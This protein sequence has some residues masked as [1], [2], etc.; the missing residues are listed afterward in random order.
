MSYNDYNYRNNRRRP[1]QQSRPRHISRRTRN[2]AIIIVAGLVIF[3]LFI[4]LIS[5]IANCI[6]SPGVDPSQ[7]DTATKGTEKKTKTTAK[8]DNISF[9]EP[10]MEYDEDSAAGEMSGDL[11]IWQQMAFELFGGTKSQAD[12][13]AKAIS[14]A[15]K[16]LGSKYKVYSMLVPNHTEIGL[17]AQFKNTDDGAETASQADYIKRAYLKLNEN[18]KYINA[19]NELSKHCNEYLYFDSDSHWTG[20]G[21]FYAYK[22]FAAETK[23][24]AVKLSELD[25][26]RIEGFSGSYSNQTE[27]DLNSDVIQY[28]S[29]P[30]E[31]ADEKTD[32]NG[33]TETY[34]TCF[35]KYAED[36]DS[37]YD[38]FMFGDNP[39]EVL[40]S[41]SPKAKDKKIAIVH[42]SWG[43]PLVPYFTY[44]YKTVYSI[45][46]NL[47]DGSLKSFCKKNK[48]D[49]VLFINGVEAST[50]KSAV[51]AINKLTD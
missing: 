32:Q 34:E 16:S 29:F 51:A 19:Y 5:S 18:V 50:D 6:C 35:D 39:L 38:V 47:W 48:I 23:L 27:L 44:N 26:N 28:W 40:T 11:Y 31:I 1:P 24:S 15:Q 22:A 33:D 45:D 42:D 9:K 30:Y 10:D 36:G 43:N 37:Y 25:E 8:A 12:A 2:R 4:T 13:Y 14:S 41:Q 7:V 49:E 3:A 46:Y 17:P 21:A 20:L